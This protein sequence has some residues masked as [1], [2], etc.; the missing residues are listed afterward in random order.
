MDGNTIKFGDLTQ[1]GMNL[2]SSI[3]VPSM[4]GYISSLEVSQKQLVEEQDPLLKEL[5][6]ALNPGTEQF[7]Q[8]AEKATGLDVIRN[9][10]SQITGNLNALDAEL[11]G[12][13]AGASNEARGTRE[14]KPFLDTRLSSISE[15]VAMKK[16]PLLIEQAILAGR[17]D[18]ASRIVESVL[19]IKAEQDKARLE[20][21]KT[22]LERNYNLFD[23]TEQRI[24]DGKIKQIEQAQKE[25]E[26]LVKEKV[27]ATRLVGSNGAP[28]SVIEKI[29][30]ANSIED[31]YDDPEVARY[32][33]DPLEAELKDLQLKKLRGEVYGDSAQ[34]TA[35][36]SKL[37]NIDSILN[38][39][40]LKTAVGTSIF[41]RAAGTLGGTLGRIFTG[42]AAGAGAG[43]AAGAPFA[44]VGAIPGAAAGAVIGGTTF[45]LQGAKQKLNGNQ[46]D[47]IASVSQ[48][49]DQE[50]LQNLIDV[51]AQGATFGALS[52]AEGK[53]LRQAATKIGSWE[54]R[55]KNGKVIGYNTS[56]EKF[57]EELNKIQSLA[58]KAYINAGGVLPNSLEGEALTDDYA[59]TIINTLQ[60]SD[61]IYKKAGY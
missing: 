16:A 15:D 9:R 24:A 21:A 34:Q 54:I 42:A 40:A 36:D 19:S 60:S 37:K 32:L 25:K 28:A 5:T 29:M 47:F 48:L 27:D 45:A 1:N 2:A 31:V 18:S 49:T 7:R 12:R 46:Q 8:T 57:V 41:G 58:E 13:R 22:N 35:L 3:N 53:S 17:E 23:K 44:G 59:N 43:A 56:E 11:I 52:D 33:R 51:K 50:F 20:I 4:S 26:D 30:R 61:Y 55:N 39:P 14:L 10:A 38:N 6:A